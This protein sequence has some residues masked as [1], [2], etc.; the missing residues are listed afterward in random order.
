MPPSQLT[1]RPRGYISSC[2]HRSFITPIT[3]PKYQPQGSA[4]CCDLYEL[5]FP[6]PDNST[7]TLSGGVA[8][9][10]PNEKWPEG[11]FQPARLHVLTPTF[12]RISLMS[13]APELSFQSPVTAFWWSVNYRI[14]QPKSRELFQQIKTSVPKRKEGVLLPLY[15]YITLFR[16]CHLLLSFSGL[17]P[18][19]RRDSE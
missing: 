8:L 7:K 19:I 15:K 14:N 4:L 17:S 10:L 12:K 1:V 5:Y 6:L 11:L 16:S 13:R 3:T 9:T 18:F 2:C